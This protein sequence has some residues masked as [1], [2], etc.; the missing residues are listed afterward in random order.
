MNTADFHAAPA[1]N[2]DALPDVVT[3]ASPLILVLL[4]VFNG[5]EYLAEQLDSILSQTHHSLLLVCR[6]DGSTDTS[7]AILT[8]YRNLHA[9]RMRVIEDNKG[10]LGASGSFSE[11]MQW[12]LDFMRSSEQDVYVA[13]SDQDD[14][15]HADKLAITLQAMT[16]VD[17]GSQPT[18]VHSDLHVV[19]KQ[20]QLLS[21]SLLDFQ[22]LDPTRT[23]F[24]AQLISN[25]VTGCTVLMNKALLQKALPV[26]AD[27][28]MHDW[29]LSLVASC[30]GRLVFVNRATVEYRQHGRNTLGARAYHRPGLSFKTLGKIFQL[31]QR[32]DAQKLFEHV[33]AQAHSFQQRFSAELS[34][35]NQ[36]HLH[37][38]MRLPALGLWGQR[39]LFRR[40]RRIA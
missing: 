4:P 27:A 16:S 19:D 26:P 34:D 30:F 7:T 18:L 11:L 5:A 3:P 35:K 13:L 8:E 21:S 28:M 24:S 17:D 39:L 32:A 20:G 9:E 22:G 1:I 38:V 33:A 36:Q 14:I 23:A 40:L 37:D 31:K 10:N 29:W 2:G 15:W 12:S 6:D 25:T